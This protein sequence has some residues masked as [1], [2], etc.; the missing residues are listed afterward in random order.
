M[1]GRRLSM[2]KIKEVLRLNWDQGLSAR[3]IAGSCGMA[4][5]TVKEFLNRAQ[6]AGLTWPLSP[7]IDDQVLE[8]L[9]FPKTPEPIDRAAP[10]MGPIHRE[11]RQP[12][13]TLQ[14]LWFEYKEQHPDGYQYSQF[15]HLYRHWAKKLDYGLRQ[16]YRAG[17]KVFV[18]FSGQ[19]IAVTNPATG[20][21]T[22][23]SLFVAVW[24]AS[25]YTY[26]EA[27]PSEDLPSWI[28]AHV[29][30]FQ[31][32]GCLPKVLVPDNPKV[33]VAKPCRYDPELNPT[34]QEMAHHYGL[35]VIPARV[36]KPKDKAKVEAGVLIVERWILAVLRNRT[37]FYLS[38]ANQAIRELLI[39]LNRRP[40]KKIPGSREELFLA[41]DKPAAR[42]LYAPYVYAQWAK[43]RVNIDY[44]LEV[45]GHY[46]SAPYPLVHEQ[47]DVRLTSTT[48]EIFFKN[49]RVASHVRSFLKGRFT[50][51]P[52]HRPPNHQN[53]LKWTPERIIGW[54]Q[55][56]GPHTAL[57]A[58]EILKSKE[59]PEQGFRACLGLIRLADRYS[60]QRLE[61]AC[62]RA[63]QIKSHS[64]KSIKSILKTGLD[65]QTLMA[66]PKPLILN[67][68]HIRGQEYYR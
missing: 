26:A 18:D 2:R 23:H 27:C 1:A 64:Y 43:A 16:E 51:L 28:N 9:L 10:D 59:Y 67:H 50:T 14:L 55:K 35:A 38:E 40:F 39:T 60:S 48:I 21:I 12:G 15:C 5:S 41:L 68:P 49:K 58:Q 29:R 19:R 54:T 20:E 36:R 46:Y 33:G 13:V 4:R 53:Y 45:Q 44:H 24:G 62:L 57:V 17:E 3:Q 56:I 11:L 66:E 34:Y 7:D 52:E 32:F 42:P 65:G 6:V 63:S 37:F 47:V 61:A 30:A 31:F 25:N 22:R 8:N